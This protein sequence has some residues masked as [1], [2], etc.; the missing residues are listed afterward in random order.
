MIRI[1][2]LL[3]KV[4]LDDW[5]IQTVSLTHFWFSQFSNI[6]STTNP[7]LDAP[8]HQPPTRLWRQGYERTSFHTGKLSRREL[9]TF[10]NLFAKTT[11]FC[12]NW[13]LYYHVKDRE[14]Q[15]TIDTG[16][17]IQENHSSGTKLTSKC[18]GRMRSR[19]PS[20]FSRIRICQTWF[21]AEEQ[22]PS[23]Y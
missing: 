9:Q 7:M 21:F 14:S 4:K 6:F 1:N 8:N 15:K 11:T 18:T 2:A 19:I 13:N 12:H 20:N 16:I 10:T 17:Q 5:E 23:F 22:F 3:F